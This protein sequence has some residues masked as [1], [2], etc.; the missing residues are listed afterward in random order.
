MHQLLVALLTLTLSVCAQSGEQRS[1]LSDQ[2]E[3]NRLDPPRDFWRSMLQVI[4]FYG[5][6]FAHC[7][8]TE[9]GSKRLRTKWLSP[10]ITKTWHWLKTSVK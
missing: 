9:G 10:F 2:N 1:T 4:D 7:L 6:L 8:K 5:T 3:G